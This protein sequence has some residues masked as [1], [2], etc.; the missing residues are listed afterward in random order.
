MNFLTNSS[1]FVLFLHFHFQ[2]SPDML[3]LLSVASTCIGIIG[4]VSGFFWWLSKL[5]Y[6]KITRRF[7]K[8]IEDLNHK[9]RVLEIEVQSTQ[10]DLKKMRDQQETQDI[11]LTEH[12]TKLS[13]M[14]S[15][16]FRKKD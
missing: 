14:L 13:L 2:L 10:N 6:K 12:E 11:K 16:T 3:R 7:M 4:P 15:D 5:I 9:V 1:Q 8:K